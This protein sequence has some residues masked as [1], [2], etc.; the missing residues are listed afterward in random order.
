MIN[1]VIDI[2]EDF[3]TLI[4]F[5]HIMSASILIGSMFVMIF[6]VRPASASVKDIDKKCAN[7][8]KILRRYIIFLIPVMLVVVSA[9]FFMNVGMGFEYGDPSAMII[10]HI[11]E[12]IW[13]FIAFNFV[14]AFKKYLNAKKAFE[15]QDLLV[16]QENIILIVKYLIPLNLLVS[17]IAAYLGIVI[18]SY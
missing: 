13:I 6:I 9:S 2:F 3:R 7:C 5:L 4:I 15:E 10:I 8:L 18:S 14:Y 17:I 11:K 12:T 16:A 1:T